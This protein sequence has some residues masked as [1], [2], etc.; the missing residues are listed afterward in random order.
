M[1]AS[2]WTKVLSDLLGN[3]TRT[4][5]IV[6]SI[7]VGL[8]AVGMIVSSRIILSTEMARSYRAI[9]PASGT[10]RTLE[11]F[12][13]DFVRSVR[14]LPA[15]AEVDARRVIEA[16]V[17]VDA[18]EWSGLTIFAVENYRQMR[19]NLIRPERGAWPP[20]EREILIERAALPVVEAEIGDRVIIETPDEK[21][22]TLRIAGT[23]HDLAQLPAQFDNTPY[24]YISFET[25]EW[26]GEPYGF[27]ELH[28][29]AE[30]ADD[31]HMAAQV[32]AQ[33][34][35]KAEKSGYT[36]PLS[37]TAEPGQVPLDDILQAVLV[38]MGALG[39]LS[40]FL[41]AFLI[42]NTISALLAQQKRQIGVMK[43]IGARTG[44]LL[45][46]YLAMVAAYGILAL[47]VAMPL[48]A[49]GARALSRFMAALFNFDIV[50]LE[51]PWQARA[52]QVLVGLLVPVLASLPPFLA[53]LRLTAA[54]A[55]SS[56]R[57]AKGRYGSGAIERLISG[58][59]LWFA[60]KRLLR[61]WLLSLRNT[62]RSKG[63]LALTLSTL[64]LAGAIFVS[65]LAVRASLFR[66]IDDILNFWNFDSL[67]MF[68]RP[69][70]IAEIEQRV[71]EVPGVADV[72][73]WTQVPVRRVRPDGSEGKTIYLIAPRAD[74]PL[75]C[76]PKIVAGR[77]LL[78]QD[79]NAVVVTANLIDE[80][81]DV[82]LGSEIVLK[83]AGREQPFH[84]VGI[85]LGI[86]VPMAYGNYPY[87][88]QISR[89]V[90]RADSALV[91]LT[92][93]DEQAI[94]RATG[95]LED[96]FEQAG[97][98]VR[99]VGSIVSERS[100]AQ[101]TFGVVIYLLLIMALL[102]ALVG[103]LGLMGT[104][105]INVLERTR[106]IGVLRALG[107]ANRSVAQ[108]FIRE[109]ILIGL[110]SWF[111]GSLLALPLSRALSDAVGLP[112]LGAPLTFTYSISGTWIL[113]ALIVALSALAS[114]L[115]ARNASRLTVRET[116]AY[117]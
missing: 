14:A 44:Q 60:R 67:V 17:Q 43:A 65:V 19:V 68:S 101:V 28:L 78:P 21:K 29:V 6:L 58:A 84:V 94:V 92:F 96:H 103:G 98:R 2:R 59:N 108:V 36:I 85:C 73:V 104:M 52:L 71:R 13:D 46:M 90:G 66:T 102:L 34:K 30:Q 87:V 99:G 75:V 23:V 100:E 5:L 9:H 109:G 1:L 32:L 53:N 40:L 93:E 115:P 105:S 70:R 88:A 107:A 57:S 56:H 42:I 82:S 111:L 3:K 61:P 89:T 48:S 35:T 38:L 62:F 51:M 12:D 49:V 25:V 106:E 86:M 55:M 76:P 37:F 26:F 20:P 10:V 45:A 24:G 77:W 110:L 114:Y 113:L 27:N 7:A 97:M 116:L 33:V 79:E 112:L 83:V 117:E 72:D 63:R 95:T 39:L 16:R 8:F 22:R 18:G 74:S 50:T 15:V 47:L 69:Y 11:P 4:M 41:S 91:A 64:T 31:P 54:E 81:P 80:E